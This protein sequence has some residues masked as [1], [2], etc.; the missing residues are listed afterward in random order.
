MRHRDAEDREAHRAHVG[1][2]ARIGAG[3]EAERES[4]RR[5][6]PADPAPAKLERR[7]EALGDQSRDRLTH[8]DRFAE[9]AVRE[10][11]QGTSRTARP[12]G[13]SS[14]S[15][16]AHPCDIGGRRRI[17]EHR[18]DRIAG[19]QMNQREGQRR[20]AERDRNQREQAANQ[21]ARSLRGLRA[22]G[23]ASVTVRER[24][25]AAVGIR[26]ETADD[27]RFITTT[28]S[29]PPQ[30]NVRKIVGGELLH[31]GVDLA[32]ARRDR[33]LPRRPP[34]GG[35]SRDSSNDR[36]WSCRAAA[37]SAESNTMIVLMRIARFRPT[38]ARSTSKLPR[39]MSP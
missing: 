15:S 26:R 9:V 16:M 19:H 6:R 2:A 8:R 39:W 23:R 25:Q 27:R 37:S 18:D 21:V 4:D 30:R 12:S 35:P 33:A 29:D 14:P 38:A 7:R 11:P 20:D 34:A 3:D 10:A 17:A 13:R 36:D 31:L 22:A 32:C 5:S 1:G 24:A 28:L